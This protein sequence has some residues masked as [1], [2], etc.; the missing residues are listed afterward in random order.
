[1]MREVVSALI[2]C[3]NVT[4]TDDNGERVLQASSPDEI[5]LVKFAEELGFRL[6]LKEVNRVVI[7]DP[8]GKE[9]EFEILENF[10]FSSERKRMGILLRPNGSD[11]LIFYLKGADT[12]IQTKVDRLSG[13]FLE[14]ECEGLAKDGLRTLVITQKRVTMEKYSEWKR[15]M[16]DAIL[17]LDNREAREAEVI[18]VLEANMELLGITGVEDLLQEDIKPVIENLRDGGI[19]VWMLTGKFVGPILMK[20]RQARD[21][22]MHRDIH[23]SKIPESAVFR[24]QGLPKFRRV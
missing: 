19:K 1:M 3:H 2:L 14:E 7:E 18:D 20:R 10:P 15:L 12:V 11:N 21:S 9:E 22:Q 23:W 24:R 4:P 5:A 17:D 6:K 8:S 13:T 16:E